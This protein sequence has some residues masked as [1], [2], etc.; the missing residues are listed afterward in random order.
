M[1]RHRQ[2]WVLGGLLVFGGWLAPEA[3]MAARISELTETSMVERAWRFFSFQDPSLRYALLGSMLLGVCCGLMGAFL[4]VRKLSL[5]G[6]SLSHAVLPGVAL[7]FLWN[8]TKDPVAI[9]VGAV[10]VGLLGAVTVQAIR[11]TTR[12]KEDAALGFVLA[13]FFGVGICL[14]T[15][16][17][18]LPGGNK[19]GLDK[20]MFGQAASLGGGDVWLLGIV[21][22]IVVVV[23]ALFYKEFLVTSFDSV[24]ARSFGLPV[25][26]FD[27]TL[28]L[29]LAFAIV[30]ALQAV[31]IVLVSAMLVIPAAAAYLLTDRLRSMLVLSAGFG[32]VSAGL[33][34]FAS[35]VGTNIPTG[36]FMVLSAACV[37]SVALFLGPRHGILMRWLRHRSRTG[38]IRREN[39]LKALYHLLEADEFET[40]QVVVRRFAERQRLTL[41]EAF[42]QIH[43]LERNDQVTL[44][45]DRTVVGFTP[46]GWQRACEIVRNHRLWEL[47]L[48]HAANYP[49][50]HVHDDAEAIEHVLSEATVMQLEKDLAYARVDPHGKL[51]PGIEDIRRGVGQQ[52]VSPGILPQS[53]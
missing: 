19:S 40:E 27:Y 36:P 28:M 29:L 23:V 21:T 8:M 48:T 44:N 20:F 16:I 32:L 1:I 47:Y 53:G 9:F 46:D 22:L 13:S 30:S 33:G 34:A 45:P 51:I 7:G 11:S 35:Y 3:A 24:F 12:H 10:A 6:D 4:V 14:L 50:D 31:G 26:W 39:T 43:D 18:N 49:A 5:M 17:Q 52:T 2:V 42:S 38:R 15:M 37:F 25:A 41:E